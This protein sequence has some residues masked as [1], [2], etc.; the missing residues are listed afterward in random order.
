MGYKGRHMRS[1]VRLA[2]CCCSTC[3]HTVLP[4]ATR[5]PPPCT[6]SS[7]AGDICCPRPLPNSLHP[8]R[9]FRGPKSKPR[10]R[11]VGLC[12][13]LWHWRNKWL[14]Y[15]HK[16]V[17]VIVTHG[18]CGQPV[19]RRWLLVPRECG[20]TS[21]HSKLRRLE[22][23]PQQQQ[24]AQGPGALYVLP[25]RLNHFDCF[26]RLGWAAQEMQGRPS[27]SASRHNRIL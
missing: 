17:D 6:S 23:Q 8:S 19:R 3:K 27:T 5:Y 11:H 22:F 7:T 9:C 21:H 14:L 4:R 18:V 26:P 25:F 16:K 24:E 10:P 13:A 1:E 12:N 20:R 2:L 15:T